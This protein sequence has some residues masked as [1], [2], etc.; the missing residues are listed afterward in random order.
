LR[1]ALLAG[2]VVLL[3]LAGYV[4]YVAYPRFHLPSVTGAALLALAAGAG[5]A[6]FFPPCSFPLLL[7]LLAS[8]AGSGSQRGRTR[9]LGLFAAA[10]SAG[11]VGFLAALGLLIALGGRGLAS[12]VTFVSATGL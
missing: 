12:S 7:T 1:Y 11:I 3:G 5:V 4:G 2:G 8:E 6:A 9:R 10:F